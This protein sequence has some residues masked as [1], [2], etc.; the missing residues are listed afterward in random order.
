M[1]VNF[2]GRSCF[3]LF[4]KFSRNVQLWNTFFMGA[5]R[6]SSEA[7]RKSSKIYN[8]VVENSWYFYFYCEN[9]QVL[10]SLLYLKIIW[11]C[12]IENPQICDNDLPLTKLRLKVI[13]FFAYILPI[14]I[15]L[16]FKPSQLD[17]NVMSFSYCRATSLHFRNRSSILRV[18]CLTSQSYFQ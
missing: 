17:L 1:F 8:N 10:F 15:C 3:K 5:I 11:S 9:P 2:F 14:I 12:L 16:Y 6:Q 4:G 7:G 13:Y 18:P